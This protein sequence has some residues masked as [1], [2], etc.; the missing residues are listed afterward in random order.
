MSSHEKKFELRD[1]TDRDAEPLGLSS[2]TSRE[3]V[4]GAPA[5]YHGEKTQQAII[6]AET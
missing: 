3:L 6:N 4:D 1:Y 2:S 5:G